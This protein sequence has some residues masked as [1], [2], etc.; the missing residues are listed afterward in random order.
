MFNCL[1]NI[2]IVLFKSGKKT[3]QCQAFSSKNILN[4]TILYNLFI[5]F[6]PFD[7]YKL[8]NVILY[9]FLLTRIVGIF[10]RVCN[11]KIISVN[12]IHITNSIC[13]ESQ[14]KHDEI[15]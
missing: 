12:L 10:F 7:A 8:Y 4:N 11:H 5:H 15:L 14:N 3:F 1:Q 6:I 13:L 2:P 9:D